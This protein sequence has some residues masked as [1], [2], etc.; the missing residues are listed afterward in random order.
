[1]SL[2]G[3]RVNAVNAWVTTNPFWAWALGTLLGG[4]IAAWVTLSWPTIKKFS[5]L[6]PQRLKIRNLK[7]RILTAETKIF[8]VER[9]QE[10]MRYL[11]LTCF[12]TQVRWVV[13]Q[14]SLCTAL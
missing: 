7:A 1:M 10:D 3:D 11:I 13:S 14:V 9:M 2:E 8:W 6:P 5:A 12:M 4:L